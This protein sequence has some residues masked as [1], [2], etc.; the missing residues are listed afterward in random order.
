MDQVTR[1]QNNSPWTNPDTE[2][3]STWS[4]QVRNQLFYTK[5]RLPSS[6]ERKRRAGLFIPACDNGQEEPW[7]LALK[8]WGFP[9]CQIPQATTSLLLFFTWPSLDLRLDLLPWLENNAKEL[10]ELFLRAMQSCRSKDSHSGQNHEDTGRSHFL[11]VPS[12][13]RVD[14]KLVLNRHH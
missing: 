1:L 13:E 8:S 9:A 4:Y 6:T 14:H 12:L 11:W 10:E 7:L 2:I 5:S 3:C